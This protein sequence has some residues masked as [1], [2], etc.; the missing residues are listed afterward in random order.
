MTDLDIIAQLEQRI[1]RKLEKLDEISWESVGYQFNENNQVIGLGL[2]NCK[3]TELP[4]E[5]TQLQN[6]QDLKI[7]YNQLRTLPPEI[8]QLQ[9]LQGL[10]LNSNQ[11]S[12]LPPEIGQLQN[13]QFLSLYSNQL[14]TCRRKSVNCKICKD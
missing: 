4:T 8:G 1:G 2:Q 3:L 12:S 5:I 6:L 10:G 14:S 11:L 9:N 7:N 13:L